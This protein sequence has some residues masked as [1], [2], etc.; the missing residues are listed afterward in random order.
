MKPV[1]PIFE[2]AA[3]KWATRHMAIA[4]GLGFAA[5][6]SYWHFYEKPRRIARDEFYKNMGVEWKHLI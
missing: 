4:L 5:A 2:G 6:E 1:S 3:R